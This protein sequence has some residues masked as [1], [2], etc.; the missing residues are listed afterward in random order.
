MKKLLIICAIAL[1]SCEKEDAGRC[2]VCTQVITDDG[3]TTSLETK[4][5]SYTGEAS[6]GCTLSQEEF[7]TLLNDEG[8]ALNDIKIAAGINST[9]R[10]TCVYE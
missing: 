4:Q 7:R 10:V 2:S 5:T 9:Y 6:G 3:V 8:Q 1:I